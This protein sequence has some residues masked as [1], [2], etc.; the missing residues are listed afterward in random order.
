MT[1]LSLNKT[2]K[3]IDSLIKDLKIK[4]QQPNGLTNQQMIMLSVTMLLLSKNMSKEKCKEIIKEYVNQIGMEKTY[5][6]LK[7]MECIVGKMV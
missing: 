7:Q 6:V 1:S 4:I 2:E 5:E 3:K